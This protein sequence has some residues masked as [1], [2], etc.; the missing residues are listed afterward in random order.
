M[1]LPRLDSGPEISE[2]RF[3][4][5]ESFLVAVTDEPVVQRFGPDGGQTWRRMINSREGS[6]CLGA[7]IEHRQETPATTSEYARTRLA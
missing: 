6:V 2:L 7:L 4:S 1:P 3:C 5:N